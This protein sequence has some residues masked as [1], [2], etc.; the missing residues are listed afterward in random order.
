MVPKDSCQSCGRRHSCRD[1]YQKL[2]NAGGFSVALEVIFA[3]LVPI[4]VFIVS[5]AVFERMLRSLH[6]DHY[7]IPLSFPAALAMTFIAIVTIKAVN[8]HL[9][10]KKV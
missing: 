2:G 3:F 10:R 4:L 9:K 7:S 1:V 8:T 6:I 5:L